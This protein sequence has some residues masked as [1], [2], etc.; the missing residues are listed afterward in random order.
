[1]LWFLPCQ[2][3]YLM[4]LEALLALRQCLV[5]CSFCIFL[6]LFILVLSC[7]DFCILSQNGWHSHIMYTA[8]Q[9]SV[10]CLAHMLSHN[11]H[12]LWL[13]DDPSTPQH[14]HFSLISLQYW[15]NGIAS[16]RWDLNFLPS[17]LLIL[18]ISCLLSVSIWMK[19]SRSCPDHCM[20][21]GTFFLHI[22]YN[23][24]HK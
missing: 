13:L 12:L 16:L 3:V 19:L 8:T 24:H 21:Y 11:T 2:Y 22:C 5:D 9:V 20:I 14:L 18:H 10:I 6:M 17:T 4:S 1:M 15:S 23:V 7:W